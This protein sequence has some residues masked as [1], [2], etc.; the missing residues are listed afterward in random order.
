MATSLG[1][2][3]YREPLCGN[4]PENGQQ[5]FNQTMTAL[6]HKNYALWTENAARIL[7]V[8]NPA[9]VNTRRRGVLRLI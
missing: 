5:Q 6:V 2:D 8:V 9:C 1:Y 4:C 7:Q 3:G